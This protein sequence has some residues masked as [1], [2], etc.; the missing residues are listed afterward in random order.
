MIMDIKQLTSRMS[1]AFVLFLFFL[2][3]QSL[4]NAQTRTID[5]KHFERVVISPHIEV[6]FKEGDKESVII[7]DIAAPFEKLNVKVKNKT[8]KIYLDG[9]EI[10]P[11]SGYDLQYDGT[12]VKAIVFYKRL[13]SLDF[14]GEETIRFA[15]QL[16]ADELRMKVYGESRVF[17]NDLI[18]DD[19]KVTLYGESY[20]K[21]NGGNIYEQKITAYGESEINA[22]KV[23]SKIA[24]ITAYG[25]SVFRINVTESLRVTSYGESTIKYTGDAKLTKGLVIGENSISKM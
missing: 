13:R 5:V 21:I 19:F 24:R 25:E 7:E 14:R 6:V 1:S 4:A 9:A 20:L 22:M 17:M 18:V 23:S 8:L 10:I 16:R 2:L 3:F 15:D 12:V 11:K